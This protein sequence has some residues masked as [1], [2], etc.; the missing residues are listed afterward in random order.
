MDIKSDNYGEF[1][2]NIISFD[3]FVKFSKNEQRDFLV[4]YLSE[5]LTEEN[6]K[7][8]NDTLRIN[9]PKEIGLDAPIYEKTRCSVYGHFIFNANKYDFETLGEDILLRFFT[10]DLLDMSVKEK[11]GKYA[12]SWNDL[13]DNIKLIPL[14]KVHTYN[15]MQLFSLES[16]TMNESS[17]NNF[18]QN[19]VS[20][21]LYEPALNAG[22]ALEKMCLEHY[23]LPYDEL[24]QKRDRYGIMEY[25]KI[26]GNKFLKKY[27][28]DTNELE[29]KM[30]FHNDK[31]SH[32]IFIYLSN[33]FVK[34]QIR[35][36]DTQVFEKTIPEDEES[37][38][39]I[40]E[41]ANSL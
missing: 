32:P 8:H 15:A 20:K 38:E 2:T 28:Q 5:K 26:K 31:V 10:F 13:H 37:A 6:I 33:G 4:N 9:K 41:I 24:L 22:K 29:I 17:Y 30:N 21:M 23:L 18:M 39:V 14:K 12:E 34:F 1:M 11:A 19:I 36:N 7:F 25:F 35:Y 40:E 27:N 16:I 3:E